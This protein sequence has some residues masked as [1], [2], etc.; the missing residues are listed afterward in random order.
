MLKPVETV[1]APVTDGEDHALHGFGHVAQVAAV[2]LFKYHIV[3]IL[4]EL[5]CVASEST[6][7][8]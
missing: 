8:I 6:V 5:D 4:F 7:R 1:T 2:I 3:S